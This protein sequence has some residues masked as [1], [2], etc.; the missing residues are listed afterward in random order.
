MEISGQGNGFEVVSVGDSEAVGLTATL[1][2]PTN[3]PPCR[4][5]FVT[6]RTQSI[7]F[8]IDGED[9]AA[10]SGHIVAANENI[11]IHGLQNLLNLKMIATTGTASVS[12]TYLR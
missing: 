6:V 7:S 1:V 10:D 9:A 5:V 2:Q 11:L 4:A 12:V 8:R 3:E